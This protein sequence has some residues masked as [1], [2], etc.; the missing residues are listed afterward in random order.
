MK[1]SNSNYLGIR[2]MTMIENG[3]E[4][5]LTDVNVDWQT[6][7]YSNSKHAFATPSANDPGSGILYNP[8]SAKRADIAIHDFL[9]EVL[10]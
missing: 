1:H 10:S 8:V 2:R 4:K 3:F 7:L 6:H 5:E 9:N